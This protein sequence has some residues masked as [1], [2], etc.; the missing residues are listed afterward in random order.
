[1]GSPPAAQVTQIEQAPVPT[2]SPPVTNTAREV[3][4]AES[5]FAK[6]NLLKKSIKKTI[7]AGDT[8]GFGGSPNNPFS[9]SP[10]APPPLKGKLG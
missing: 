10:G 6:E 3:V 2:P 8:G 1:M 5:D 7:F 9:A 4:Q